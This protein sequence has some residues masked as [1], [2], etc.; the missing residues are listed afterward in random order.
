MHTCRS[1]GPELDLMSA[2]CNSVEGRQTNHL[3]HRV[4]N[5]LELLLVLLSLGCKLVCKL[6]YIVKSYHSPYELPS[7]FV[8]DSFTGNFEAAIA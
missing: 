2:K 7:L 4:A 6:S 1:G 3:R 5:Q 8:M